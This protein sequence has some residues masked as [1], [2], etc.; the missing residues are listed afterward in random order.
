M[1]KKAGV[2]KHCAVFVY[3]LILCSLLITGCGAGSDNKEKESAADVFAERFPKADLSDYD[4]LKDYDKELKF[5]DVTVLDVAKLMEEKECFAV[6]ASFAKCPWCNLVVSSLNDAAIEEDV[7]VLYID[8]RK[9]PE[10]NSNIE[11]DD[12]DKFTELFGDRLE[13]DSDGIP[14]L[15]T[16]HVFF[17]KGGKLVA[18]HQGAIPGIDNPNT[19]LSDDQKEE[20][21]NVYSECLKKIK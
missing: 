10:W 18:D 3:I 12:Y 1:G 5:V 20:L 15:Y 7:T 17:V 11:I 16:P 6:F 21:K 2:I 14:H 19:V 8:T 9:N 13:L 4:A